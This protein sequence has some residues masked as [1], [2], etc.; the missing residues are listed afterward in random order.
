[1]E[2]VPK[3]ILC[4]YERGGTT[5]LSEIFRANGYES[6]FECGALLAASPQEFRRL[7]PYWDML[8]GGWS[9][10]EQVRDQ[11]AQHDFVGFYDT[12]LRA[13]FPCHDGPFFDKTPKYME[14]LA[15]VRARAPLVTKA[16]VIHRDPR[17]VFVSMAKRLSPELE[18]EAGIR[19]N[20][21]SLTSRY[22]SYFLGAISHLQ[23]PDTLFVPFEELVGREDAWL[24]ALGLFSD[25]RVFTRRK[26]AS[27]FGN[28]T[29]DAMDLPKVAEFDR[30][31]SRQLQSE[32]LDATRLAALFVCD[33]VE[34]VGL[35]EMWHDLSGQA[36]RLLQNFDLPRSGILVEGEPFEPFAYLLRYPD[37]LKSGMNPVMHFER[38]GRRERRRPA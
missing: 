27:R 1:M 7:Q 20:F 33:P 16:V 2:A 19:R 4:G 3:L 29:S 38:Y 31:L 26:S 32:I 10:S 9:V 35:A 36:D 22:L 23:S 30:V 15:L 37:V 13:A 25:G 6:G 8:P 17:A 21:S 5:L 14:Q 28:V 24:K 34:R 18:P 11:A 12:L